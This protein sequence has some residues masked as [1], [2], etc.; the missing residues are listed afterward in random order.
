MEKIDRAQLTNFLLG[1]LVIGVVVLFLHV[2][3]AIL[4]SLLVAVF[5][6]YALHPVVRWLGVLRLP[7]GV[8]VTLTLV[9]FLV[10]LV[11]AGNLV[12]VSLSG[13]NEELPRYQEKLLERWEEIRVEVGPLLRGGETGADSPGADRAVAPDLRSLVPMAVS[14]ATSLLSLVFYLVLIPFMTLFMLL[15]KERFRERILSKRDGPQTERTAAILEAVSLKI[16]GYIAGRGIITLIL[17]VLGSLGYWAIGLSFPVVWGVLYAVAVLVPLLGI[18]AAAIPT[19][20]FALVDMDGFQPLLLVALVLFLLQVLENYVLTPLI[21]GDLVDLNPLAVIVSVLFWGA[22][23]GPV[24][25]LLAIP[26]TAVIKV[27]FDHTEVFQ[28]AGRLL[29]MKPPD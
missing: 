16:Q 28:T 14:G 26:I 11:L 6:A 20:L 3:Q 18:V 4:V 25:A 29:G 21:L 5:L 10:F 9:A 24:G 1:A 19:A 17:A 22:L 7:Y 27:L 13:L 8:T 2:G 15:E 12:V 23:W